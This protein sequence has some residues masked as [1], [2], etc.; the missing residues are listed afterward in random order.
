MDFRPSR[1]PS[2]ERTWEGGTYQKHGDRNAHQRLI[3]TVGSLSLDRKLDLKFLEEN[4]KVGARDFS[5]YIKTES[6]YNTTKSINNP[7]HRVR[8]HAFFIS[9]SSTLTSSLRPHRSPYNSSCSLPSSP[10]E[11]PT[12]VFTASAASPAALLTVSVAALAASPIPSAIGISSS[13][14]VSFLPS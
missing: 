7:D 11:S 9:T 6:I 12:A 5:S 13:S 1:K 4:R 14:P 8:D 3:V 2:G 10:S